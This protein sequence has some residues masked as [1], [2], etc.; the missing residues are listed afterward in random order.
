MLR[1]GDGRVSNINKYKWRCNPESRFD[2]HSWRVS[3]NC[4]QALSHHSAGRLANAQTFTG[5]H[6]LPHAP[7]KAN[8]ASVEFA[9]C[10]GLGYFGGRCFGVVECGWSWWQVGSRVHVLD[11]NHVPGQPGPAPFVMPLVTPLEVQFSLPQL[12]WATKLRDLVLDRAQ[13]RWPACSSAVR[14]GLWVDF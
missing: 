6:A 9:Q 13:A 14:I 10:R 3:Q 1:K 12:S 8:F 4:C 5:F 2:Q 11:P 7:R